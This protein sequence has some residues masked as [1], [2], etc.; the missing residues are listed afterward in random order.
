[1]KNTQKN[2]L[3]KYTYWF[4]LI[5][6]LTF[7]LSVAGLGQESQRSTSNKN[8]EDDD[9]IVCSFGLNLAMIEVEVTN[10]FDKPVS[11]LS[12]K[13]FIIYENGKR[14]NIEFFT[15]EIILKANGCG[16]K[17]MI[18]YFPPD[19]SKDDPLRKIRVKVR[20]A[21]NLGLNVVYLPEWYLYE[22]S[23]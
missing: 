16:I 14:Q 23:K 21:K 18:G 1:V 12:Y 3:F 22:K 7:F 9:T 10:Q 17:Y 19:R 8:D 11:G 13:D 4:S 5:I 2:R 6:L 20:K 15:S